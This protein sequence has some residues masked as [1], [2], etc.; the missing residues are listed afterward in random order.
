MFNY[1]SL[2]VKVIPKKIYFRNQKKYV[3]FLKKYGI[4]Q[5]NTLLQVKSLFA[6]L[7]IELEANVVK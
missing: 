6:S 7:T 5:A 4:E 2:Q 1:F 3:P